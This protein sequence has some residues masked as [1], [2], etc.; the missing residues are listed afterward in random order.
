MLLQIGAAQLQQI[1]V[2]FITDWDSYYK[3]GQALL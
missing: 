3:L 2:S 1:E